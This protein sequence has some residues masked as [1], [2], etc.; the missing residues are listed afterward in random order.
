MFVRIAVFDPLPVYRYGM[1]ATLRDA[2]L[3]SETPDDLFRWVDHEHRPLV[4]LTLHTAE[5]WTRLTRLHGTRKDV[6]VVAVLSDGATGTYLRAFT[7]GAV[8]ALPRDSQPAAVRAT[9]EAVIDGR[10]VLPIEVLQALTTSD[11]R[12]EPDAGAP[13]PRELEWLSQ[14]A[15]GMTV[16]DIA[17]QAGYS[18]RMMFRLLRELYGRM[19]VKD[20][21]EALLL[22]RD[23]GWL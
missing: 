4:L 10:T 8:A 7:G 13:T 16:A 1:V 21:T 2:G 19:H 14:M 9:V 3:G 12:T 11:M 18:E 20:R 17:E 5:D 23:R 22:A 15:T 6:L